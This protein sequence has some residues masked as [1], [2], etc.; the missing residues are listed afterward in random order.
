MSPAQAEVLLEVVR[1]RPSLALE[2][3]VVGFRRASG[4]T[5]SAATVSKY[6]REAG[7]TRVL[8]ARAGEVGGER[9]A[10]PPSAAT[11]EMRVTGTVRRI[12]TRGMRCGIRRA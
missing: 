7:F 1:Y 10:P 4:V 8:R 2:D 5:V 12:V 9:P 6:V 11:K 3:V